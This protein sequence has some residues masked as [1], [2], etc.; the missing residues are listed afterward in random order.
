MHRSP[1]AN[2]PDTSWS[3]CSKTTLKEAGLPSV[4]E[5]KNELKLID[6]EA[7]QVEKPKRAH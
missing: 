4:N 2:M 5:T 7:Q 6:N 3:S 1:K